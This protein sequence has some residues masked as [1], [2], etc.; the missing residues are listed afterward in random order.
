MTRY[1]EDVVECYYNLKGYFTMK[2]VTFPAIK[3]RPGGKGRG[4]IDLLAISVKNAKQKEAH[5]VEISVSASSSFPF[6]DKQGGSADESKKIIKKFFTSDAENKIREFGLTKYDLKII[7]SKHTDTMVDRLT[8]GL[9]VH[10]KARI[11]DIEETLMGKLVNINHRGILKTIEIIPFDSILKSLK[12]I[13]QKQ[14]LL[15]KNFE[16]PR[17]RSIQY[18]VKK[19]LMIEKAARKT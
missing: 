9:K 1:E 7:T 14:D 3:K 11:M 17:L 2:N 10:E 4:E 13:Y 16:D 18:Y 15:D 5:W 6:W 19:S 12:E 8:R